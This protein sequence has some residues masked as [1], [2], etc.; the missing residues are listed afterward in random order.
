M[1]FPQVVNDEDAHPDIFSHSMKVETH[2]DQVQGGGAKY[3]NGV[4][5]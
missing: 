4:L 3:Q 1:I 5:F 2:F